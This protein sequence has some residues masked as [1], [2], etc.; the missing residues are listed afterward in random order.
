MFSKWVSGMLVWAED[1][2]TPE[3]NISSDSAR[4]AVITCNYVKLRH[5]S[6]PYKKISLIWYV[7]LIMSVSHLEM[8]PSGALFRVCQSYMIM[9]RKSYLVLCKIKNW[10]KNAE[11]KIFQIFDPYRPN[12]LFWS[13]GHSSLS[14]MESM[15]F[16]WIFHRFDYWRA[17]STLTFY[18]A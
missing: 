6:H 14:H 8:A 18:V 4:N 11:Q 5:V 12:L 13:C 3:N 7:P 10:P 17:L 1:H 9:Y 16:W 15:I 2:L